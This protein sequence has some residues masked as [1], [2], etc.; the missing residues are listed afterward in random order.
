MVLNNNLGK[1]QKKKDYKKAV[2]SHTQGTESPQQKEQ[3]IRKLTQ[4]N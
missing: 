1:R 3:M 4:K 2:L